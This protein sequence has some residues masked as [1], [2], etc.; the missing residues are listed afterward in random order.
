MS[1]IFS[2]V[3]EIPRKM[4]D[5]REGERLRVLLMT[6][7]IFLVI[8][9]LMI[10]KSTSTSLFLSKFTVSKLPNVFILVAVFAAL[11]A[12]LYSIL[13]KRLSLIRL[14]VN[15]L[16]I[17]IASLLIFKIFLSVN[18]LESWTLYIFYVWS[19]I[20][21]LISASQFWILTNIMFNSREVKRLIGFIGSGAIG[22]GI[23]G[24]YLTKFLAPNMGSGNLIYICVL[25]LTACILITRSLVVKTSQ[26]ENLQR[27]RQQQQT[28][29]VTDSPLTLIMHS[30]HLTLLAFIL[31]VSVIVGKL[32]EYQFSAI[33]SS[34]ITEEDQLTAFFGFWFSNLNIAS[35]FI[36]LLS[37]ITCW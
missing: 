24:G 35:L 22:G 31:G 25:F 27:F 12:S 26:D 23:F 9:S 34:R 8:S 5:I 17:A 2:Y 13:L 18:F 30:R 7:Y 15:T 6:L 19:A 21:A 36:Q 3:E 16:Q 4:F 11:M 33:A 28:E 14:I 20:F 10:I 32:V 29:T 1:H 37:K